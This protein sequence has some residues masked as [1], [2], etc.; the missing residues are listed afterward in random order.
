MNLQDLSRKLRLVGKE[1][2]RGL[3][4]DAVK[5]VDRYAEERYIM[6]KMM[7]SNKTPREKRAMLEKMLQNPVLWRRREMIDK[8]LEKRISSQV[9]DIIKSRIR[10]GSLPH[11]DKIYRNDPFMQ[12]L[13]LRLKKK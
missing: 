3:K 5:Q 7:R 12:M 2:P 8:T 13:A 4:A 10:S 1:I 9:E 11:P 6:E